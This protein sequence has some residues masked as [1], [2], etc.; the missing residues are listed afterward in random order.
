MVDSLRILHHQTLPGVYLSRAP[1]YI[2][3]PPS[4]P[5]NSLGSYVPPF[6]PSESASRTSVL[7]LPVVSPN[8]TSTSVHYSGCM[9]GIAP[10]A[11]GHQP[12]AVGSP[13]Q[14][15]PSGPNTTAARRMSGE[16]GYSSTFGGP[17]RNC[18]NVTESRRG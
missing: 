9:T 11:T 2:P 18:Y 16:S 7:S 15:A 13:R 8:T 12:P 1:L 17:T 4:S 6:P 3:T 5:D 10:L 14:P